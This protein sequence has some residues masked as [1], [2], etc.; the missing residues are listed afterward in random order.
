MFTGDTQYAQRSVAVKNMAWRTDVPHR[1]CRTCVR[2]TLSPG[3][4]CPAPT[5]AL[6]AGGHSADRY[7][8]SRVKCGLNSAA[9]YSSVKGQIYLLWSI[10]HKCKSTH[11]RQTVSSTRIWENCHHVFTP[12]ISFFIHT[13]EISIMLLHAIAWLVIKKLSWLCN[14]FHHVETKRLH[15]A[16]TAYN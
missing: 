8:D 14:N 9:R 13:Q 6:P 4:R 12:I 16:V 1:W 7:N 11:A 10:N 2:G 15:Y 5:H 3:Y